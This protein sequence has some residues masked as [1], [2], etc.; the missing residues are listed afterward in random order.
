MS[1]KTI[2]L[3]HDGYPVISVIDNVMNSLQFIEKKNILHHNGR[4]NS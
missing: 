1:L 3:N 4:R 2:V